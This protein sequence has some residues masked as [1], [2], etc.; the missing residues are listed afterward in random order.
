VSI[1]VEIIAKTFLSDPRKYIL[2][3][4]RLALCICP[5]ADIRC[6]GSQ[7]ATFLSGSKRQVHFNPR[8]TVSN[9]LLERPTF[10]HTEMRAFG[11]EI[12]IHTRFSCRSVYF[13]RNQVRHMQSRRMTVD[14]L[15]LA[16]RSALASRAAQACSVMKDCQSLPNEAE[17]AKEVAPWLH[18]HVSQAT[19]T[20]LDSEMR[21]REAKIGVCH[22]MQAVN[23][24]YS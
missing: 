3:T 1:L 23:Q 12:Y 17:I 9:E 7:D 24:R 13:Y 4:I 10:N 16:T 6:C 8:K 21:G 5:S 19:W 15:S 18:R 22:R 20:R 2:T 14:D 11:W